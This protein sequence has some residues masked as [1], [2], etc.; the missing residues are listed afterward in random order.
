MSLRGKGLN[1]AIKLLQSSTDEITLK[2]SR[3]I[4]PQQ[5]M[6]AEQETDWPVLFSLELSRAFQHAEDYTPSVDSAMESWDSSN[7]DHRLS[8][9]GDT[10]KDILITDHSSYSTFPNH[11]DASVLQLPRS[12][13]A[14]H[15]NDKDGPA[16]IFIQVTFF[17]NHL[18]RIQYQWSSVRL[19]LST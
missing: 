10:S 17:S 16:R 18:W 6:Q 1:E 5:S 15:E 4:H 11:S 3:T 8:D 19:V 9:H 7:T 14:D 13:S 2:I 12:K